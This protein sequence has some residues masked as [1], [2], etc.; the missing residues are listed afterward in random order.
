MSRLVRRILRDRTTMAGLILL[1]LVLLAALS[2]PLLSI[3]PAEMRIERRL[4]PPSADAWLGTD[5]LGNDI[6]ARIVHGA[7]ITLLIAGI[8]VA[9]GL[10]IGVPIGLVAGYHRSGLSDAMMRVTDI[11]LAIP[12][13]VLA[14]ALTQALGPSIKSVIL[15]LSLTYWPLWAR[16]VYAETRSLRNEIFVES[17]VAL[18]VPAWRVMVLH[19]LP[20]I[21]S[22]IAVRT[23]I[24]VGVTILAATTLSFLGLGAPPP[25]PEWGRMIAE[26]REYLPDA[27][28]YPVAPGMAIFLTVLGCYLFGDGLRDILD[29]RTREAL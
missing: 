25:T 16:L 26:S 1:S 2:A 7:G 4:M 6:L 13:I 17:A 20:S 22:S 24:G 27:W 14:I 21:A 28:W 23:S 9:I 15:A 8:T 19:I 12:Q 10:L 18:G 29:P 3:D 11:T 5:R